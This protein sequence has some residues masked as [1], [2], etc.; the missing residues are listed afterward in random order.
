MFSQ[1][2]LAKSQKSDSH[3]QTK[4]IVDTQPFVHFKSKFIFKR[5]ALWYIEAFSFAGDFRRWGESKATCG[6]I[7][8]W[9]EP[10]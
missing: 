2:R 3:N 7:G 5:V 6:L 1:R 8:Q 10:R 9:R 4:Q